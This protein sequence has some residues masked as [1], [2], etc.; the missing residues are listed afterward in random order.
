MNT[1][2]TQVYAQLVSNWE[3]AVNH[4][5]SLLI[6][7]SIGYYDHLTTQMSKVVNLMM[8]MVPPEKTYT[9]T[10]P[11]NLT[12]LFQDFQQLWMTCITRDKRFENEDGIVR[13]TMQLFEL[14]HKMVAITETLTSVLEMN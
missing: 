2:M 10:E 5:K 9:K 6:E 12:S 11:E 13:Y 3:P 14:V 8:S 7:D 4:L 1:R